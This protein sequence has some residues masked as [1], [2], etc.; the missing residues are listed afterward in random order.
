M[1]LLDKMKKAG[2]IKTASILSKSPYFNAKDLITTEVPIVNVAFSADPEGGVVPGLTVL[3]G[4]SKSYKTLL[5]L[6][7]MKAYLDKYP[8]AVALLYDSEFG[9]TPEYLKNNGIDIDRVLHIPILHIEE[10]KFDLVKRL[11]EIERGDKV[12]VGIDSVGAL[13]SKK[14]AEDALEEKSV[15]DMT[16]AKAL[17]GLFRIIGPHFTMKDIPCIVINHVYKEIGLYPKT[18]VGGGT[19]I[20]YTANTI[21][22][23][24]K[25]QEK[26]GTELTGW[27]FTLNI[28]KS[29][30]VREK[31]KFQFTVLYGG[32]L[33]KYSGLFDLALELGIITK[34][35]S[36]TY[37]VPEISGEKT[38]FR[39]ALEADSAIWEQLVKL[40]S[41]KEAIY[42]NY[43][44]AT[45]TIESEDPVS[46]ESIIDEYFDDAEE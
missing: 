9:I 30:F 13:A 21:F 11:E 42:K 34:P 14:E 37:S 10:L 19:G 43:S 25:S 8:D 31:A 7:C 27:N 26:D 23:I 3:A 39:K 4:E 16:R 35:T 40:D 44:Y 29:R 45:S 6:L 41:F 5:L 12:F 36:K 2:S 33:Q 15:A 20:Y 22:I 38:Y 32:G 1:S 28:E 17:K 24:S 46:E 18:I